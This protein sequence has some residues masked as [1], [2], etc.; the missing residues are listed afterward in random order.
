MPSDQQPLVGSVEPI[1]RIPTVEPQ[2]ALPEVRALYA[3]RAILAFGLKC[4]RSPQS[5]TD[6][7]FR[8]L[9]RLGLGHAEIVEVVATSALAVYANIL[10]DATGVTGDDMFQT[11]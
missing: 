2:E 9:T 3:T 6:E 8:S 1:S 11:V 7:D 10:A 5:L 4:A